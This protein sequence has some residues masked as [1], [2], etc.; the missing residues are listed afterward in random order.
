MRL[1]IYS[2][3]DVASAAYMRPF[4]MMADSQAIRSFTDIATDREHDIGKH[5]EDYSLVRVGTFGDHKADLISEDVQVLAT[6]L[7]CIAASRAR[8]PVK[9][10]E[11]AQEIKLNGEDERLGQ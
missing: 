4:F 7:E 1:N 6:A 3:F 5:P 9:A 10:R 11:L 8:D 2:I